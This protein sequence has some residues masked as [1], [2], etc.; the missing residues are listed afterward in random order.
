[1]T[2]NLLL[3][4]QIEE[5]EWQRLQTLTLYERD[6]RA[7]GFQCIA[8]VDEAGRGP[9]AG[10]VVAA[11][12][13][14]PEDLFIPYVND[15]KKVPPK[16]RRQLFEKITTNEHIIYAVGI[17]DVAEIDRINI[18]QAT[19]QA[20]LAAVNQLKSTPNYLVVDGMKL[21]HPHIPCLKIIK[22]D[23][24]SQSI[25]TASIIAKETRDELM[26]Q[27][28]LKWPQYGFDQHK[29]YGTVQHLAALREYGPCEIHRRSFEPCRDSSLLAEFSAS[30]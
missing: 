20:M 2:A 14:I 5:T 28:H 27:Y 24:L 26:R 10:P 17:I 6:L 7:K 23:L 3:D 25:A 18:Y 22:G 13:I 19:V 12:C 15:S 11:A 8:G 1:M 16:L 29:G 9:L 30:C 4:G 21:P